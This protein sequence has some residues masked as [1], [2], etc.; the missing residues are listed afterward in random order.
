MTTGEN[1]LSFRKEKKLTQKRLGELCNPKISESTIRKYELGILNP[2][3]ETVQ[4]IAAALGVDPFSLYSFDMTT[5][6]KIRKLRK[7]KGLTQ[8]R[9]GELCGINEA[10]IRKYELGNQNPKL[11]TIRK[12]ADA[13]NA[14]LDDLIPDSF[15]QEKQ[16]GIEA[17]AMDYSLIEAMAN[18][19]IFTDEERKTIFQEIEKHRE[20]LS[21][22]DDS[23]KIQEYSEKTHTKLENT[24]FKMLTDKP[25]Y[26]TSNAIIVLSC[27]L[28]LKESDQGTIAGMLFEYFYPN[29]QLMY[30]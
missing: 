3:I 1:I 5:G 27:F 30:E 28:S 13:L 18:H 10:N 6:E 26:D 9:L 4:K 8:K 23:N 11:S 25:N 24:L 12:I 20:V 15:T 7:E 17:M 2:K 29:T 14:S 19:K 22:L 16:M 21:A